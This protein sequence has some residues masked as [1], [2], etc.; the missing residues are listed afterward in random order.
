M[1]Y[2]L[3]FLY[4]YQH[5][6][7]QWFSVYP[8]WYLLLNSIIGFIGVLIGFRVYSEKLKTSN[9]VFLSVVLIGSGLVT[10][11]ILNL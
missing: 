11:L 4:L 5:R 9:G 1:L 6:D 10:D 8:T 2:H 3:R 7:V